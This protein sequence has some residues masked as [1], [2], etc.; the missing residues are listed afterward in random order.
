MKQYSINKLVMFVRVCVTIFILCILSLFLFSF[1]TAKKLGDGMWQQLGLN[2]Q[3]GTESI[4]RSFTGGDLYY[5]QA[6]NA[7]NIAGGNRL[8]IAKDLLA[9]AKQYVGSEEFKK[10]YEQERKGAKPT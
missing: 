7:R 2:K 1:V 8:A 4:Y 5:Y 9:Y 10:V 6:R 3:Q